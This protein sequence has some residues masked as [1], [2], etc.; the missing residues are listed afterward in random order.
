MK[1][2]TVHVS[3]GM[4]GSDR[5]VEIEVDDD[6]PDDEIEELARDAM[7]EMIEWTWRKTKEKK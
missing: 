3:T 4:Q 6:T 2:I 1:T 7:F 5:E